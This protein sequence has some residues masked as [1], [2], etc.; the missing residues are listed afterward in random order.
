MVKKLKDI[1]IVNRETVKEEM[2]VWNVVNCSLKK[3][4]NIYSVVKNVGTKIGGNK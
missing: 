4:R 3:E 2:L 1:K